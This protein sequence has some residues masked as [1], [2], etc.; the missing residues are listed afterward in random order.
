M[1]SDPYRQ[2]LKSSEFSERLGGNSSSNLVLSQRLLFMAC[3][4]D[5]LGSGHHTVARVE[6]KPGRF[7]VINGYAVYRMNAHKNSDQV[8]PLFACR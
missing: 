6:T 3:V 7:A 4:E 5:A 2:F 1:S 8:R